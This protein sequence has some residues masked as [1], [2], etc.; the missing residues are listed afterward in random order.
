[1]HALR[2]G[3]VPKILVTKHDFVRKCLG[4][5]CVVLSAAVAGFV[6]RLVMQETAAQLAS[7]LFSTS[8]G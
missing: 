5:F 4:I 7:S 2:L 6:V 3:S 1:M 8:H